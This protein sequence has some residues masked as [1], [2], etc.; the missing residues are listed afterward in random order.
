VVNLGLIKLAMVIFYLR[1][2]PYDR[3]RFA[4]WASLGFVIATTLAIFFTAV[5]QCNPIPL[6]WNKDLKGQCLNINALA[7][8][9]G[10]V[11][12]STDVL[13]VALP[14][15]VISKLRLGWKKKIGVVF[16]FA[17][18]SLYVTATHLLPSL[19]LTVS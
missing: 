15:P 1:L 8:A 5:F 7:N 14:I 11:S 3:F 18:G 16:M 12:I 10:A 17:V 6:Y 13:I 9:G 2:F 19:M 4:A